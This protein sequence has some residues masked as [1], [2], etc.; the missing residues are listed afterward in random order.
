MN[1]ERFESKEYN[2]GK[3]DYCRVHELEVGD[4]FQFQGIFFRVTFRDKK[5]IG[6]VNASGHEYKKHYKHTLGVKSKQFV[7][8]IKAVLDVKSGNSNHHL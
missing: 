2:E 8:V 3:T 7:Q 6:Y 5:I 1:S 4:T